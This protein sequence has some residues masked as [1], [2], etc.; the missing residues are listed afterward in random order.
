MADD[1]R[2]SYFQLSMTAG[3]MTAGF[4]VALALLL[5]AFFFGFRAG[6][7]SGDRPDGSPP[8]VSASAPE[9]EPMATAASVAAFQEPKGESAA[10]PPAGLGEISPDVVDEEGTEGEEP[11]LRPATAEKG[12]ATKPPD[13]AKKSSSVEEPA[14]GAPKPPDATKT[15]LAAEPAKSATKTP[16]RP[17][18]GT[19][20]P[21]KAKGTEAPSGGEKTEVAERPKSAAPSSAWVVQV[22]ALGNA[23][24]AEELAKRLKARGYHVTVTKVESAGKTLH[25]VR[26]GAGYRERKDADRAAEKLK[27]NERLPDVSVIPK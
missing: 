24:K 6:A 22:G 9:G 18:P 2:P 14:K 10:E 8:P 23:A 26:V 25:A 11:A 7:A 12:S 21:P 4:L 17:T 16:D 1:E 27:T 5:A 19:R 15:S 3:Q 13:A 20:E